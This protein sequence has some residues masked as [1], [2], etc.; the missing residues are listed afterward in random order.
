MTDTLKFY[1]TRQWESS[2]TEDLRR[3]L[4]MT[5]RIGTPQNA[6]GLKSFIEERSKSVRQQLAGIRESG[7]GNGSGNGGRFGLQRN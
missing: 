7:S 3:N 4:S 2:L 6:I 5:S 1:S